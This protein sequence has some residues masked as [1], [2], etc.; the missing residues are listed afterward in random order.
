M[1]T[2][3]YYEAENPSQAGRNFSTDRKVFVILHVFVSSWWIGPGLYHEDAKTRR[4]KE[5]PSFWLRLGRSVFISVHLWFQ[6][7]RVFWLLNSGFWIP[8]P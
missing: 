1:N 3:P 6:R 5:S 2:D 4:R 8:R 7:D